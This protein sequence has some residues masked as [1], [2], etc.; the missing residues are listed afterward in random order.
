MTELEKFAWELY[1]KVAENCKSWYQLCPNTKQTFLYKAKEIA[2][3]EV[4][5]A[6]PAREVASTD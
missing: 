1:C 4:L 3:T 6:H 5:N 2:V